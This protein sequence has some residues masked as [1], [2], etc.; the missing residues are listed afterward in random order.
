MYLST[1][2]VYDGHARAALVAR[3]LR[4]FTL[5]DGVSLDVVASAVLFAGRAIDSV[6]GLFSSTARLVAV[7]VAGATALRAHAVRVG[8]HW[9][10]AH[11]IVRGNRS[12]HVFALIR[13]RVAHLV[14]RAASAEAAR[15]FDGK[16]VDARVRVRDAARLS[17][18]VLTIR[19][20][21]LF[22]VFH[23]LWFDLVDD[24]AHGVRVGAGARALVRWLVHARAPD[25]RDEVARLGNDAIVPRV[26]IL[27]EAVT[28]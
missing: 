14:I 6:T 4:E 27:N 7:L 23:R 17:L 13:I 24:F 1:D 9:V 11:A 15:A 3:V 8:V 2:V 26:L 28:A 18:S 12:V 16:R 10:R 22:R 21:A 20:L 25:V 5:V 19:S